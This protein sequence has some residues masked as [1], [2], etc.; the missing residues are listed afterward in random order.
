[1]D[2]YLSPLVRRQSGGGTNSSPLLFI[3]LLVF[4]ILGFLAICGCCFLRYLKRRDRRKL[5]QVH[6]ATGQPHEFESYHGNI[7]SFQNERNSQVNAPPVPV[8]EPA[9]VVTTQAQILQRVT[10]PEPA[11]EFQ[12]LQGHYAPN[13]PPRAATDADVAALHQPPSEGYFAPPA[14]PAPVSATSRPTYA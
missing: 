9:A 3:I 1:M 12:E 4:G 11:Q 6:I 2:D 10:Q 7:R 8:P 13:S 5:S 14:A